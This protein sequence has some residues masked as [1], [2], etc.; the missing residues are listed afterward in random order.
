MALQIVHGLGAAH[1][2]GI[3]HQ[4][5][6]PENIFLTKEGH[7]KLLD[8]GLAKLSGPFG[9]GATAADSSPTPARPTVPGTAL[10]TVGYM[11]PEQVRGREADWRSDLFSF[12]VTL[13]GMLTGERAF[14]GD[15]AADT[16]SAILKEDPPELARRREACPPPG[17]TLAPGD[18]SVAGD[19][20]LK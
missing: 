8:F 19:K 10:G 3:V 11:S 7:V 13:Y 14:R 15:S 12:G 2:K 16:M 20:P 6:K 9:S 1:A 5:L 4:D 18:H 17:V